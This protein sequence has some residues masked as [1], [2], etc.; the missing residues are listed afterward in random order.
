MKRLFL[1]I[2]LSV[3]LNVH[4]SVVN[5]NMLEELCIPQLYSLPKNSSE[6]KNLTPIVLSDKFV[7]DYL[8]QTKNYIDN[9]FQQGL[10]FRAY[11]YIIKYDKILLLYDLQDTFEMHDI[12]LCIF[13]DKCLFPATMQLYR[14]W[15]LENIWMDFSIANNIVHLEFHSD[16]IFWINDREISNFDIDLDEII[17]RQEKIEWKELPM[18]IP[19]LESLPSSIFE[20]NKLHP[21]EMKKD[22]VLNYLIQTQSSIETECKINERYHALGIYEKDRLTYFFYDC[23][24]E[25]T[26]RNIYLCIIDK[27]KKR[28]PETLHIYQSLFLQY[29]SDYRE[30]INFCIRPD[31]ITLTYH[32]LSGIP[33]ISINSEESWIMTESYKLNNSF[34]LENRKPRYERMWNIDDRNDIIDKMIN[35]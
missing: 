6:I 24:D 33:W 25:Y 27:D 13:D 20:I 1:I 31:L 11:G 32:T 17:I 22:F 21:V 5:Q 10:C 9:K 35:L 30:V 15:G 29:Y 16:S 8:I 23:I 28:Y 14:Q 4:G 2:L 19:Y 34:T 7:A 12:Y 26:G 18:D 3:C